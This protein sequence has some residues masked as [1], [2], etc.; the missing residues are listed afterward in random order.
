MPVFGKQCSGCLANGLFIPGRSVHRRIAL[1]HVR[2][3]LINVVVV[4]VH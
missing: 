1:V 2:P 3:E 4:V